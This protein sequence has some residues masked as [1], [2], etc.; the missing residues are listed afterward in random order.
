MSSQVTSGTVANPSR[1]AEGCTTWKAAWKS[2][3]SMNTV[4][5]ISSEIG[6]SS[7]SHFISSASLL[8]GGAAGCCSSFASVVINSEDSGSSLLPASSW[9]SFDDPLSV[10]VPFSSGGVLDE[11]GVS[12]SCWVLCVGCCSGSCVQLLVA[13]AEDLRFSKTR[14]TA[15]IAASLKSDTKSAPTKPGLSSAISKRFTSASKANCLV[16][17]FNMLCLASLSGIPRHTSRS[18]RPARLSAGSSES[19]RL[20][21]P[22]TT[23]WSP[24]SLVDSSEKNKIAS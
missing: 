3:F 11:S 21:A 19:G 16:W 10:E 20:V 4:A 8:G 15:A 17:T 2:R 22:R 6:G 7:C 24:F 5:R 14:W 12:S 1:L 9:I 23:I 18:N 13:V